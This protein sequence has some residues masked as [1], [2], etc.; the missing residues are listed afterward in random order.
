M[1]VVIRSTFVIYF[2]IQTCAIKFVSVLWQVRG[3]L[4]VL[5]FPPPINLTSCLRGGVS[6]LDLWGIF[7]Y[8]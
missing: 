2:V 5:Q 7:V 6:Y 8:A 3:F 1:M 4:W